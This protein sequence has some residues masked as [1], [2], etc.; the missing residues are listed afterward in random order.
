MVE[1]HGI[2]AAAHPVQDSLTMMARHLDSPR[3]ERVDAIVAE[4]TYR[5]F[6]TYN[7]LSRG[8]FPRAVPQHV[9]SSK[10][11]QLIPCASARIG[12]TARCQT[13][14]AECESMCLPIS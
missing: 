8:G 9:R 4:P 7:R 12:S 10:I 11:N 2:A 13:S 3:Q 1:K 5:A 14:D 6:N